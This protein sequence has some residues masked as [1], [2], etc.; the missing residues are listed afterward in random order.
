MPAGR[1]TTTALARNVGSIFSS[2][3]ALH[4]YLSDA[5]AERRR[6]PRDDLLSHLIASSEDGRLNEE[7]L[8]WF[9]FLL[10]VAGNE[11]TT[12]L[13]GGM[14]LA[15]A[16]HPD[17][18]ARVREDPSLIP[19]CVEESLRYVSPIQGLYRTALVDHRVGEAVIPAGERVLLAFG[20][21][22]RDPRRYPEP[23]R[24]LVDRDTSDHVAFGSGIHFCLGAQLARLEATAFL[25]ELIERAPRIELAGEPVWTGNPALR[26]MASLP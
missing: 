23:D 18:Y 11:T 16:R 4:R 24:F 12:S 26:A 19:G 13:I 14:L 22:N 25:A 7:E 20:A 5:I 17:Q 6:S 10:L 2:T 3:V 15:F 9:A 8:F 1:C 21:A